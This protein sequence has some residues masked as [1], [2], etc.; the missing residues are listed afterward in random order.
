L[1]GS[2]SARAGSIVLNTEWLENWGSAVE[3]EETAAGMGDLDQAARDFQRGEFEA[4]LKQLGQAVRGHPELP[5]AHALFAKLAIEGKQTRLIRPA[6][7][8]AVAEDPGHPEVF[9]LFGDLAWL[10]GRLTDASVHFEKAM[11]LAEGQ[12]WS[13]EQRR[14]F[15]RRCRQ[16]SASVAEARADWTAARA[17][18]D[19]W[20][21]LE[22]ANAQARHRLG[23]A[24]FR[25]DQRDAAYQELQ[26]AAQEDAA[27]EPAAITMAWLS[28]RA[29][30]PKKAQEWMDYAVKTNLDSPAVRIAM[31]AWL[32]EQGRAEEAQLQAGAALR[33]DPRSQDARR[34]LG[35]A[36]RARKDFPRAESIFAAM[37]EELPG[38]AWVRNQLALVLAE[39]D[40][41]AKRHKAL[42]LAQQAARQTPNDPDALATLGIVN[43]RLRRMDQAET[44]LQAVVESGRGSS[45]AAYILARVQADRGHAENAPALL[46]TAL[47]A[48]GFFVSRHDA[49][50]W[51]DRLALAS[52][53]TSSR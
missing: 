29:G 31:T 11:T 34:L 22:P 25:L 24:L 1:T 30:D 39:Q 23:R 19:A 52:K 28:T 37:A 42:E 21:E 53:S 50:Q 26:R 15:V 46:E 40:D 14:G 33:L 6:L 17:A 38:D 20:L 49:R 45:D 5:P 16:G 35:L 12:R 4:C 27:L 48:P 44:V 41:D 8:R 2:T 51:L 3:E 47:A 18:L 32:L 9:L 43:Y 7:E 10:D 36:A 13:A